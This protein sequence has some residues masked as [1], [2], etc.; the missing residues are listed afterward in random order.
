MLRRRISTKGSYGA[1]VVSVVVVLRTF[2]TIGRLLFPLL[3]LMIIRSGR[4]SG[5]INLSCA[6]G[7]FCVSC[8]HYGATI[9]LELGV[10]A[11]E[12][13][14]IKHIR[15]VH[16]TRISTSTYYI[17]MLH[18]HICIYVYVHIYIY[19]YVYTNC[20]YIYIYIYTYMHEI[21]MALYIPYTL[22]P[23][24][25]SLE[26]LTVV[27]LREKLRKLQL[28]VPS[29][30]FR[31]IEYTVLLLVVIG[32]TV[33]RA[34]PLMIVGTCSSSSNDS[35]NQVHRILEEFTRCPHPS[36]SYPNLEI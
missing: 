19:I 3:C 10:A 11:C 1:V 30:T 29:S 36:T 5:V 32:V 15:Y 27:Q 9:Q 26:Q 2:M 16:I 20:A 18:T 23:Q 25:A 12:L 22:A 13:T 33:A 31:L 35:T 6:L 7:R 34:M 4:A 24:E 8:R 14:H 21:V 28:P 17:H